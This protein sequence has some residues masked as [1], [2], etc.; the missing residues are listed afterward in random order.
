MSPHT[1][2]LGPSYHVIVL[3]TRPPP[4]LKS[5]PPPQL[6]RTGTVTYGIVYVH[7]CARATIPSGSRNRCIRRCIYHVLM[8]VHTCSNIV[9]TITPVRIQ[10]HAW[11]HNTALHSVLPHH[12]TPHHTTP[13]HTTPHHTIPYHTVP[14]QPL[15]GLYSFYILIQI[16]SYII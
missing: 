6:L 3:L 11:I 13:H 15:Y 1:P 5:V 9:S 4:K 14:Y 7:K 8:I 12:T 16:H 10:V 2:S